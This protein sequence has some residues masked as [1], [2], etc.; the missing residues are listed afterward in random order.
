MSWIETTFEKEMKS[1]FLSE[2]DKI[3][4]NELYT[5]YTSV[6]DAMEKDNFF[7]EI[8][9]VEKNL[10]D[11]SEKHIQDVFERAFLLIGDFKENGLKVYD[12]YCLALMILFHDVGNIFGRDGHDSTLRIATIYNK[13]RA[14]NSSYREERKCVTSGA[15]AHSGFSTNGCKDT[16]KYV[17]EDSISV[18]TINL[19]EISAILRLADELAEG[20][21][22]TCSL[23]IENKIISKDSEIFH[24]YASITEIGISRAIGRITITYNIDIPSNFTKK[25][26]KSLKELMLFTYYRAVKLDLE[27]RYTKYYSNTLSK[28]KYVSVLYKFSVDE[29][30]IELDL[31]RIIFEDKYPVP[32]ND[33]SVVEKKAESLFIEQNNEFQFSSIVDK[34]KNEAIKMKAELKKLESN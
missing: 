23:L 33:F 13:Y 5:E 21:H 12:V 24:R 28:Y 32:G 15:S 8:K 26:Q 11:H 16:L 6:R 7:K 3:K 22:R 2:L 4:A 18:H 14:N 1:Y 27:R 30:P 34:L 20:K 25:E 17:K 29:L 31:G 10:S 9:G 19:P